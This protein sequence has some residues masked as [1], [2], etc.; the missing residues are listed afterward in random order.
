MLKIHY[1]SDCPFFA[2]CEN[3]LANFFNSTEFRKTHSISFSFRKSESYIQGFKRRVTCYLPIYPVYLPDLSNLVIL[4]S[5][6]PSTISRLITSFVRLLLIWPLLIYEI[7]VLYYIFK[8]ISP[9]ILHINN[10]GYP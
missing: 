8:R 4:P 6:A 2:G 3:M 9:D 1:H 7:V 5:F 10:G